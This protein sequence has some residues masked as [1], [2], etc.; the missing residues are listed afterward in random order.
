[1]TTRLLITKLGRILYAHLFLILIAMKF[2][3]HIFCIDV[4]C[5]CIPCL[6]PWLSLKCASSNYKATRTPHTYTYT[7]THVHT[8]MDW[9]YFSALTDWVFFY[10]LIICK[11]LQHITGSPIFRKAENIYHKSDFQLLVGFGSLF[12]IAPW[13]K[14]DLSPHSMAI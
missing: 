12:Q 8:H 3:W 5:M 13:H 10:I 11:S 7:Y 4:W 14:S 6:L 9:V 2:S 1:M